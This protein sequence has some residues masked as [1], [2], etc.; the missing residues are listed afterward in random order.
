LIESKRMRNNFVFAIIFTILLSSVYGYAQQTQDIYQKAKIYYSGIKELSRLTAL[1]IPTDHGVHKRGVF[2]ISDFSITELDKARENGFQVEVIIAD[3]KAHFLAQNRLSLP[4]VK[5]ATCIQS[6]NALYPTPTNFNLG[7]M[8]GYLT[9]QEVLDELDAMRA[10]FPNLISAPTNISDPSGDFLTE[11][12]VDNSVTPSIGGNGIKWLRIS[13][14]PDIDESS[15]PK[16]LYTAIHHARE[17][18]SLMQ[19]IFYMW[20]L[21]ENY[22]TDP[23]IQGIVNNTQLYFVPVVN[24]DGYLFNQVTNPNG[25][26]FWR[27]NRN[28]G[29]GVDNNRNYNFFIDG[30][31]NNGVWSGPG[32]SPDV[33]SEIYH[34]PSPFSEVEN[35]AIRYLVEN[36]DFVMAFNNHT[37]GELWYYPHAYAD[38]P[39]P[40]DTLLQAI[41]SELV[42]QNGYLNLRGFPFSGDSDDF[43]YGT[44][45]THNSILAFTPEIGTQFWHPA[46]EIEGLCKEM[47]FSN[48]TGAKMVN[49]FAQI[50]NTSPQY[51]GDTK[52]ATADFNI[53]RLGI[54]GAGNFTVSLT[55]ISAN[56]S[57]VGTAVDFNNII[58]LDSENGSIPFT[59]ANGTTAGD[60]ISYEIVINNGSFNSSILVTR[61][62]GSLTPVFNAPGNSIST[63]F[64]NN[65]WGTTTSTFVSPSS[66]ITDSPNGM[67]E[68]N[69]DKSIT[70]NTPIDLTTA[71]GANATFHARWEIEND[72][73]YAQ[74]QISIDNGVSWISQCGL[75]TNTGSN[76]GAQPQGE[77]L[78]DGTQNV[79]VQEQIDLSDYLGE[80]ILARFIIRSDDFFNA[81]GFFFDDLEFNIVNDSILLSN[82][83]FTASQFFVA[84]NPVSNRLTITTQLEN[85]STELY[86]ITGQLIS[87]SK[88]NTGTQTIDY[89]RFSKGI[90]FLKLTGVSGKIS[91][92]VKIIKQ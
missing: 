53:R 68:T 25:G 56:I 42:S 22:D 84:P 71:I 36:N 9:Y 58:L 88:E 55:P 7:S 10:Q 57:S 51:T 54:N 20:Y 69:T 72:F 26:G 45:G 16:I 83:D 77:P 52:N 15:E 81:D 24:P 80:T 35:Q 14:N 30:N 34:G 63:F 89:S 65:G 17:P 33:N 29:F 4:P 5:N 40:D 46:N 60:I 41:S 1:G 44:L 73:D 32:S 49:N 39:T 38:V 74:F 76:T 13:D 86:T 85:Y 27:K 8:G 92:T 75:F 12:L 78:Y 64:N 31:S 6:G 28:N 82:Q 70:L 43:M 3:S 59:I 19:L 47:M 11:G 23:E 87:R 62:F 18:V 37:S 50:N 61:N 79:W 91:E 48:L 90:Y 66:S 21:L 67:Y 2:L